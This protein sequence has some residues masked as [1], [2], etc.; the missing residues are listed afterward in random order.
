MPGYDGTG[1]A[2]GGSMSGWG[3]GQCNT[4]GANALRGNKQGFG[5]ETA[6]GRGRGFQYMYWQT[7]RPRWAR[8]GPSAWDPYSRPVVS[9]KSEIETLNDEA[10]A[11]K[12]DLDAIRERIKNLKGEQE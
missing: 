10:D 1:P 4:S 7:G 3:R 11:L 8:R 5:S 6:Y 12:Q 2:G 9:Y